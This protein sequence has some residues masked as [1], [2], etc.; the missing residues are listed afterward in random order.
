VDFRYLSRLTL[1]AGLANVR[2]E[3]GDIRMATREIEPTRSVTNDPLQ[4]DREL[5]RSV[6]PVSRIAIDS[7]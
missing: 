3:V 1:L 4:F 6:L 5:C 2:P 7:A